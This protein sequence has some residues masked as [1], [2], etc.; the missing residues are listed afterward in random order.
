V[1][2]VVG[3][4]LVWSSLSL[5]IPGPVLAHHR[6]P[7]TQTSS[8]T[9]SGNQVATTP[10]T[11]GDRGPRVAELQRALI[12]AGVAVRGGADGVFGAATAQALSAF[13]TSTGLRPTGSLDVTTAHLLGLG[14]AP[15]LPQRGER[16]DAVASLQ[17]AL[18]AAGVNVR[19]GV[20]GIFGGATETAVS[21]FQSTRSLTTNGRV[22]VRT[23][24]ALGIAPQGAPAGNTPGTNTQNANTQNANTQAQTPSTVATTVVLPRRGQTGDD[25]AVLQRALMAAGVN[26]RGGADGVFGSATENALKIYQ[27]GVRRPATGTLDDI[28]ARLLGL[29]PAPTVPRRGDRGDAVAAVQRALIS[30]DIAIR[31]G[32]DGVFGAATE[33]AIATFQ[34]ALGLTVTGR[35]DLVTFYAITSSDGSTPASTTPAPTGAP[36]ASTDSTTTPSPI[37]AQIFP[38]QGPCW[39]TDT[40]HAPRSGGRRH[41]GVDIIAPKGKAVYAVT[42]GII[43]R[44]F[45]DRPG[46]LGGNALR[47]TAPDGTYFHY[48]HFSAFAEGIELGVEVVA[49]QIIGYVGSTGSSSTPHLHFEYHPFGGAAVN[50]YPMVK[51]LDA[52][53]VVDVLP[54]PGAVSSTDDSSTDA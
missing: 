53:T 34:S 30:R 16:G 11:R 17:R 36:A 54:Q 3:V 41:L 23:A 52:C 40:W 44:T 18:I 6:A 13:Q 8:T 7:T 48:A 32:A 49:G 21:S 26:V 27:H 33:N 39:F 28:T 45:Q 51:K 29:L 20:D 19:G 43:T 35:L 47:L 50:P 14:P 15:V 46:S 25:V 9:N 22:D 4:A 2:S 24:I 10:L 5:A 31:G 12:T 37:R 38:V 42:D 1:L